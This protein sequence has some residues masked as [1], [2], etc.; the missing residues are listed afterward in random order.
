M[1]TLNFKYVGERRDYGN[2]N[3]GFEDVILSK[4]ATFD[5]LMNYKLFDSYNLSI[6]AKY[7]DKIFRGL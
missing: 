4:Y 2:V 7:F 6:S 1:H 5:Y 3:Q